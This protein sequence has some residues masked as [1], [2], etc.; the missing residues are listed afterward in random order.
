MTERITARQKSLSSLSFSLLW[1]TQKTEQC[2]HTQSLT[3]VTE[4]KVAFLPSSLFFCKSRHF[5]S[6][7]CFLDFYLEVLLAFSEDQKISSRKVAT[8]RAEL[9]PQQCRDCIPSLRT[10]ILCPP[11]I[12]SRLA[13]LSWPEMINAVRLQKRDYAVCSRM[14]KNKCTGFM[15]LGFRGSRKK[16]NNHP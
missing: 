8:K 13:C 14:C 2:Q 6:S 16:C 5:S 4:R 9:H 1:H 10:S 11:E 7:F 15:R 3:R 12:C